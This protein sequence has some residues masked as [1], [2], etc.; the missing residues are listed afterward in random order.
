MKNNYWLLLGLVVVAGFII[1]NLLSPTTV[2]TTE[3]G[4]PVAGQGTDPYDSS[5]YTVEN[6]ANLGGIATDIAE[7]S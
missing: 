2:T 7:F 1:Y 3:S 5:S 6:L 4:Q